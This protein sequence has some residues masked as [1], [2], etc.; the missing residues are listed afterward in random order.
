MHPRVARRKITARG[1]CLDHLLADAHQG[2]LA[3]AVAA[4]ADEL[5]R[6]PVIASRTVQEDLRLLAEDGYDCV[7]QVAEKWP[8]QI[9][10]ELFFASIS[11]ETP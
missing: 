1:A 8:N 9:T 6:Q 10:P 7:Y 3:V 2:T 4:R 11:V 5:Q